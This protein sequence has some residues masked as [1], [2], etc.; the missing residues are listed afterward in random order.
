MRFSNAAIW[1]VTVAFDSSSRS[2]AREKLPS[3]TTQVK[4]SMLWSRSI[5]VWMRHGDRPDNPML[6]IVEMS[7]ALHSIDIWY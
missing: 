6:G 1:A 2:A 7:D 4:T 5:T 3:S